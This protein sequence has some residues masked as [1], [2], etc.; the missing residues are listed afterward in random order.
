MRVLSRPRLLRAR[1][2]LEVVPRAHVVHAWSRP[3]RRRSA[4]PRRAR[5]PA[6][7]RWA[8]AS[9]PRRAS[10]ALSL[11]SPVGSPRGVANDL[12]AADVCAARVDAGG[13][14][15]GG[16]RQRHVAV[17]PV[18]PHR[19][20]GRRGVDP[21]APRQ[22]AAPQL[23]VPVAAG[24]PGAGRHASSANAAMRATNSSRVLASRSC[25]EASR[26]P[27]SRKCT[28]ES[29]KPGTR[30]CPPA[31][32]IS[33]GVPVAAGCGDELSDLVGAAHAGDPIARDG[34]GFGGRP[35][36][37][38]GPD[39][40]VDDGQGDRGSRRSRGRNGR[41]P[42]A[43]RPPATESAPKGRSEPCGGGSK[44]YPLLMVRIATMVSVLLLIVHPAKGAGPVV[45]R[46]ET[47]WRHRTVRPHPRTSAGAR[48]P[49]AG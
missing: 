46:H 28:C 1:E 37:I 24:D 49:P 27:P 43:G 35:P 8:A 44:I 40:R 26:R 30:N 2:D 16:V 5:G 9:S 48:P 7:P 4:S 20:I 45:R 33:T 10:I 17:E 22:L 32:M 21:L 31:S 14:Q 19:M 25:T 15:R 47:D 12:A 18:H 42:P 41:R 34:D 29:M 23:M 39:F 11:S 36:R 38:T 3:A 6:S 13:L